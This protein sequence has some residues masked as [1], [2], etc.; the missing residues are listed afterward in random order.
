MS[1]TPNPRPRRSLLRSTFLLLAMF[2]AVSLPRAS[3]AAWDPNQ[4]NALRSGTNQLGNPE[5]LP[6]GAGGMFVTWVEER[7]GTHYDVMLQRFNSGGTAVW[8]APVVLASSV[9]DE[10]SP[11]LVSD[12]A[13]GVVVCWQQATYILVT[14]L[15]A[16]RVNG[17][18]A[19]QWPAGGV[20]IWNNDQVEMGGV[21]IAPDG[22]G[23]AYVSWWDQRPS[24][25]G[26]HAQHVHSSGGMFWTAGGVLVMNN[27]LYTTQIIDNGIDGAIVVWDQPGGLRAQRLGVFGSLQWAG[28]RVVA[29]GTGGGETYRAVTDGAGGVYVAFELIAGGATDLYVQRVT[30]AGVTWASNGTAVCTATGYQSEPR[31]DTDGAGGAVVGWLDQRNAVA[32][33]GY[34]I[35]GSRVTATGP[36]VAGWPVNGRAI[37]AGAGQRNDLDLVGDGI[38][39]AIATWYGS[40]ADCSQGGIYAQHL[41][42]GGALDPAF[43]AVGRRLS[44]STSLQLLPSVVRSAAGTAIVAWLECRPTCFLS[45]YGQQ[46]LF[47]GVTPAAV[48]NLAV[49]ATGRISLRLG[50]TA[51]GDDGT[52][53]STAGYDVRRSL[54]NI[55]T[56]AQFYA[57]DPVTGVPLPP[58]GEHVCV[59]V[60][61]LV[62][63]KWYFFAVRARDEAN[64]WSAMS[65]VASG[66]TD[67]TGFNMV[68][69]DMLM[70]ANG[71]EREEAREGVSLSLPRPN[72]STGQASLNYVI[73]ATTDG[74]R[75]EIA[76]FDLAGRRVQTVAS[77]RAEA[78]SHTLTVDLAERG[79][80]AGTYFVRLEAGTTRLT[81]TLRLVR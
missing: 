6:D 58:A 75:L 44:T 65:N 46:V 38:G 11:M 54:T 74:E 24:G 35:Y 78:G 47:D 3:R 36:V 73:D 19:I 34:E 31:I 68:I 53:G 13:G 80:R 8:G 21:S 56:L 7:P 29:P 30:N 76:V 12:A 57:A 51:P 64:N 69:C 10:V 22:V 23:G 55:T 61:S 5:T 59:E 81:R 15:F 72:P 41:A 50:W 63:C 14:G 43:P 39:G 18:G 27:W 48:A 79:L 62:K 25:E 60:D 26:V 37:S 52:S 66:K 16:Q 77:G 70:T 49:D 40:N 32:C 45:I 42:N 1:R 28:G 33:G 71:P 9:W 17:S 67:C 4:G 20:A 2:V